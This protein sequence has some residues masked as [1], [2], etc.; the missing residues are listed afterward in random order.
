MTKQ[1]NAQFNS[2]QTLTVLYDSNLSSFL[3]AFSAYLDSTSLRRAEIAEKNCCARLLINAPLF[4]LLSPNTSHFIAFIYLAVFPICH[5][6]SEHY[7]NANSGAEITQFCNL[8]SLEQPHFAWVQ[9]EFRLNEIY[10]L[11]GRLSN[12][13]LHWFLT[14]TLCYDLFHETF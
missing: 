12:V 11:N 10:N 7:W 4:K 13:L 14:A 8:S 5:W 1:S 9:Y 2:A 3:P 6:N